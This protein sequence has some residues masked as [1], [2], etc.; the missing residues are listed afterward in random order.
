MLPRCWNRDRRGSSLC[1]RMLPCSGD[2]RRTKPSL[3]RR[4]QTEPASNRH[5]VCKPPSHTCNKA[6]SKRWSMPTNSPLAVRPRRSVD[7]RPTLLL[8]P[9]RLSHRH[10]SSAA[11]VP[12]HPDR[13]AV[14]AN[15]HSSHQRTR[16]CVLPTCLLRHRANAS[17]YRQQCFPCHPDHRRTKGQS[18]ATTELTQPLTPVPHHTATREPKR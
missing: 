9:R 3:R 13:L 16:P 18:Q 10:T 14:S 8:P 1:R 17:P 11:S 5:S 4:A 6:F 15:S 12:L 2:D 7:S